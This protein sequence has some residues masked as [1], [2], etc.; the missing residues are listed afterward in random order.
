M[1]NKVCSLRS[2]IL[3]NAFFLKMW[4]VCEIFRTYLRDELEPRDSC[5]RC[6]TASIAAARSGWPEFGRRQLTIVDPATCGKFDGK[7]T[8]RKVLLAY[9]SAGDRFLHGYCCK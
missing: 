1:S 8:L 4:S 5:E 3:E 6:T 2:G 9:F 7:R